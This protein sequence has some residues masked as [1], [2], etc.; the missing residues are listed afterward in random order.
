MTKEDAIKSLQIIGILYNCKDIT[1]GTVRLLRKT[2]EVFKKIK[3]E[4]DELQ[5]V[6]TEDKEEGLAAFLSEKVEF[7]AINID[8]FDNVR[9]EK[10]GVFLLDAE[11][12]KTGNELTY[13]DIVI[14][15]ESLKIIQ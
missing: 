7:D 3:D 15:L 1:F 5:K 8:L 12:Q 9:P 4:Y 14:V 13:V 2:I 10:T 11:G 6:E